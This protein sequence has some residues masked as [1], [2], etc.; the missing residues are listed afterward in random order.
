MVTRGNLYLERSKPRY[1]LDKKD[2]VG[3]MKEGVGEIEGEVSAVSYDRYFLTLADG[4]T[5]AFLK[6]ELELPQAGSRV[7][8]TYA[9]GT[10]PKTL[11]LT[12]LE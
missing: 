10:P 4:K 11:M 6:G 3:D 5:Q 7:S 8:V 12:T 2:T 9:G 1:T